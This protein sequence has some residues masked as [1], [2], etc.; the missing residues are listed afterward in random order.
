MTSLDDL[1]DKLDA[2][3]DIPGNVSYTNA[4]D[5]LRFDMTVKKT[6]SGQALLDVSA[7]SGAVKLNG[8]LDLSADVTVHLIFGVDDSGFFIDPVGNSGPD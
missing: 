6:L 8:T 7:L 3:D 1:R 4:N 2:L 5:V